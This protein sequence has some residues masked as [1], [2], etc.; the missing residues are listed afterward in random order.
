MTHP[1][2]LSQGPHIC[3]IP[4]TLIPP[5]LLFSALGLMTFWGGGIQPA[6]F[7]VHLLKVIDCI[8]LGAGVKGRC[9]D[10]HR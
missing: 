6:S 2:P 10:V 4:V 3:L 5:Q 7:P 9:L 1:Q 8:G